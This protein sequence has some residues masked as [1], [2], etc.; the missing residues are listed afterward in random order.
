M[1]S[2]ECR[3]CGQQGGVMKRQE[4]GF[5]HIFCAFFFG[6]FKDLLNMKD[7]TVKKQF[8]L[9]DANQACEL[10][11]QTSKYLYSCSQCKQRPMHPFCAWL[12]GLHFELAN[13]EPDTRFAKYYI[14]RAFDEN[15]QK[16]NLARMKKEYLPITQNT[17][18]GD[19]IQRVKR[20]DTVQDDDDDTSSSSQ[21]SVNSISDLEGDFTLS[22]SY[23]QSTA[24]LQQ[25]DPIQ[26]GGLM[27]CAKASSKRKVRYYHAFPISINI[28]CEGCRGKVHPHV[29]KVR[30]LKQE[31]HI[32]DN[33]AILRE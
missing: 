2:V 15:S 16:R 30:R 13:Q 21:S 11:N 9:T 23:S 7:Y 17:Y 18:S 29:Q 5:I 22:Q 1:N 27:A 25:N 8:R 24:L 32:K 28:Y 12:N 4:D 31:A 10:C 20:T 3:M 14:K 26:S 33:Q 6:Q 19:P